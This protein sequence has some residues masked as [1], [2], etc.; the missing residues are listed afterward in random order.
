MA[1]TKY[2]QSKT[3][4]KDYIKRKLGYPVINVEVTDDQIEDCINEGIERFIEFAEGGIQHRFFLL[5]VTSGVQEYVLDFDV[6]SINKVYDESE[7]QFEAVFPDKLIADAYGYYIERQDLLTYYLSQHYLETLNTLTKV[8]VLF[9]FNPVTRTLYLLEAPST[10][11]VGISYFQRLDYSDT[12]SN[13]YDHQWIKG[14]CSALTKEQ[15]GNNLSKYAGSILPGGL[16]VNAD[17]I[18]NEAKEKIEKY[19][20]ELEEVWKLPTDF[21]VG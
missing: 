12:A 20:L 17:V 14:Y 5:P 7:A 8:D 11:S 10:N 4:L 2:V 21:F 19:L 3:E 9:D 6:Y 1:I 16:T 13:L 15:W 18:L